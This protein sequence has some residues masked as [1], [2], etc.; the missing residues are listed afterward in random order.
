MRE[1]IRDEIEEELEEYGVKGMEWN[2]QK[3][4][5][6]TVSGISDYSKTMR[7]Y[8][9][10]IRKLMDKKNKAIGIKKQYFTNQID[11]IEKRRKELLNTVGVKH[12]NLKK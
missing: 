9:E 5:K 8:N 6:D 10:R 7:N 1:Y 11:K 2:K 3:Q 12:T 4:S